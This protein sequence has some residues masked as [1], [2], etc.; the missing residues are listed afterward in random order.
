MQGEAE[1]SLFNAI[2]GVVYFDVPHDGMDISLIADTPNQPLLESLRQ[3]NSGILEKMHNEYIKALTN[4][5]DIE[6]FSFYGTLQSSI[7]QQVRGT[8]SLTE[9]KILIYNRTEKLEKELL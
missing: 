9:N 4:R 7:D 1:E 8:L 2:R 5:L 6:I 3:A